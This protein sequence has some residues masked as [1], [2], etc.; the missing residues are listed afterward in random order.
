MAQRCAHCLWRAGFVVKFIPS[1]ARSKF[2]IRD[3]F[4]EGAVIGRLG[5]EQLQ[6]DVLMPAMVLW[7]DHKFAGSGVGGKGSGVVGS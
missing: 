6:S 1:L 3:K 4:L 5:I 2:H 7:T